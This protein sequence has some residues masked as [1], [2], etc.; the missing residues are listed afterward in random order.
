MARASANDGLMSQVQ[1]K[2]WYLV[3]TEMYF[4]L[5][6]SSSTDITKKKPKSFVL[7]KQKVSFST[8]LQRLTRFAARKSAG[9]AIIQYLRLQKGP[10]KSDWS[11]IWD[12]RVRTSCTY[13]N[14]NLQ[15]DDEK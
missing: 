11:A 5:F 12:S 7:A 1:F 2:M 8:R 14:I 3:A 13:S 6:L 9:N 15:Y 10:W 4:K